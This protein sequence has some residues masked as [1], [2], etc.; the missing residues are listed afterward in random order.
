MARSSPHQPFRKIKTLPRLVLSEC[1]R[2]LLG[3]LLLAAPS[4][5]LWAQRNVEIQPKVEFVEWPDPFGKWDL[6]WVGQKSTVDDELSEVILQNAGEERV[7][8][9]QLGWVLFIPEGC[10][11]REDGVPRIE[12]HLAP[13]HEEAIL[14][15]QT[16][17][18][19]PYHL[20][21]ESIRSFAQHEH[22]PAV[23]VQ[24]SVVRT[25]FVGRSEGKSAVEQKK[26]FTE[27]PATYPCE[28]DKKPAEAENT[29]KTF[30][31]SSEFSFQYTSLL[32]PCEKKGQGTGDGYYWA[33]NSCTA[34]FPVCDDGTQGSISMVCIAYPREKFAD[35]PTF[36]AAAFSVATVE[37]ARSEKDCLAGSPDWSVIPKGTG[38]TVTIDQVKFKVF[39]VGDAG[40]SQGLDGNVYRTFHGN[41][42]YQLSIKMASAN[43]GAFDGDISEFTKEDAREVRGRLEQ[44][45]DSFRFL[46]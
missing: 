46:K 41:K 13:Y 11:V 17:T 18:T 25:G 7:T 22:S 39:E 29:M 8:G 21:S 27:E 44:A 42:C 14:P 15:G 38:Q 35:A 12:V 10:G 4:T 1:A 40:M 9:F 20:S 33:Q 19:G 2:G 36:E 3:T 45:R 5:M 6:K 43:P 32:I 26:L 23:V 31:G 24:A 28:R 30:A 37:E 34:Y 16:I